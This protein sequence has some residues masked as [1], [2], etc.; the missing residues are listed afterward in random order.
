[1]PDAPFFS[2]SAAPMPTRYG[3]C[4]VAYAADDTRCYDVIDTPPL[5][6]R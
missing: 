2:L 5:P 1:M 6:S 4:H 3:A